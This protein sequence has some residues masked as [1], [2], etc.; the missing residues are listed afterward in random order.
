MVK[1]LQ[2]VRQFKPVIGGMENYVDNLT[3]HLKKFGIDSEVLT[4]DKDF[5][6]GERFPESSIIHGIKVTRIPYFGSRRYPIALSAIKYLSKFDIVHI[7]GVDF[8]FDYLT[9]MKIFHKK[10]IILT[11]HGGFF[12]TKKFYFYKKLHFSTV[13]KLSLM[14]TNMIIADSNNDFEL[15]HPL[16]PDKTKLIDCGIDFDTYHQIAEKEGEKNHFIFVGRF[17]VNKRIDKLLILIKELKMEFPDIQLTIVGKDFDQLKEQMLKQ[18]EE[19]EISNHVVIR[20][21]LSQEELLEEMS[22][23]TYFISASEY[24]GFGISTLEAMAAGRTPLLNGI[25]SFKKMVNEGQNGYL[26][27]FNDMDSVVKKVTQVLK[28]EKKEL[29]H[30]AIETAR[31]NSWTTMVNQFENIYQDIYSNIVAEK[32]KGVL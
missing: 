15:F 25:P 3:V 24:E 4:L 32:K 13:T 5:S 8:L 28:T 12:H 10:P 18:I 21:A 17:A 31:Q 2:V 7:H 11:T 27:D 23:C 22:K 9:W 20:E 29:R 19:Y 6:N 1:V 30:A 26:L 16:A 14:K